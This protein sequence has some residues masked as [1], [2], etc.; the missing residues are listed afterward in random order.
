VIVFED[1]MSVWLDGTLHQTWAPVGEQPRVDT[2]GARKTAHIYGTLNLKN[3]D[4][5]FQF[6]TV[7]NGTTF[8]DFVRYVVEHYGTKKVF[9][10]LD[11]GPCHWLSS[12]GKE[13]LSQ[14]QHRLELHRLPPY[15]PE[16]NPIEGV[17]KITRR[18]T[19]HY[20]FYRTVEERDASL[21][22]TFHTFQ[23]QPES[24]LPQVRRFQ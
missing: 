12:R 5:L 2:F 20:R 19:T 23:R 9:M 7:F 17:W 16:F 18:R 14:N 4:F 22:S 10:I 11:N 1:E 21:T 6:A 8:Y 13:W 24:L 3:G 15:S